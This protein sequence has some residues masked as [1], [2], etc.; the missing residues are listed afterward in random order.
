[1][2]ASAVGAIAP[3]QVDAATNPARSASPYSQR[4]LQ[5]H[6]IPAKP[7]PG[8]IPSGSCTPPTA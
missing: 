3:L 1:M 5:Q 2:L 8:M 4:R 7:T 6:E